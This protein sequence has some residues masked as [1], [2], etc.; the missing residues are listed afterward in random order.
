MIISGTA[1]DAISDVAIAFSRQDR[2]Q[3]DPCPD[4]NTAKS[5]GPIQEGLREPFVQLSRYA[6]IDPLRQS[7]SV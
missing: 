7:S 5:A 4:I 6:C 3:V 2:S 1:P